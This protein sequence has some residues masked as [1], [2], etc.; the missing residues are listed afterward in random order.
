MKITYNEKTIRCEIIQKQKPRHRCSSCAKKI[1]IV[2][3]DL[4][5]QKKKISFKNK[6]IF[7]KKEQDT[8][9]REKSKSLLPV[10]LY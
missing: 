9:K 8:R 10:D 5:T 3:L 6:V 1:V 4:C 2:S 7:F